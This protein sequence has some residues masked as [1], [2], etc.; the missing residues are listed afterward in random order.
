MIEAVKRLLTGTS[1][2]EAT[3]AT[4]G[5][6]ESVAGNADGLNAGAKQPPD[7]TREVVSPSSAELLD[8]LAQPTFALDAEG[9]IVAWNGAIEEL[10]GASAAEAVGHEHASEMF[11]PDGRRAKTLADKV[12]DNPRST[13]EQHDVELDDPETYRVGDSSTMVDQHGEKKHIAFWA[14]PRFDADGELLGVVE[15]VVDQ[16]EIVGSER[17]IKQLVDELCTTLTAVRDGQFDER[18]RLDDEH[19]SQLREQGVDLGIVGEFNEFVDG[20]ASLSSRVESQAEQLEGIVTDVVD[21]ADEIATHID[22]Q[23]GMLDDAV[24]EMQSFSARMEEVAATAREVDD[25]AT[26]ASETA[27]EGVETSHD[28]RA[29]TDEVTEIG[30]ELVGNIRA[31]DDRMEDI[32]DGRRDNLRR[33]RADEPPRV[34]REHRGRPG[35]LR[36]G[37]LHRRRRG[38]EDPRRRDA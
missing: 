30:D 37:R 4:D 11:Y 5:G 7:E 1:E 14:T 10:T 23:N 6:T 32:G 29:A 3:R 8:L 19:R 31:L 25:A 27:S 36:R 34:E 21:S 2:S 28:A 15:V 33:G 13:H 12:L 38:G 26:Q 18:V 9:R 17:A 22:E 24:S 20:F 35:R 16:T